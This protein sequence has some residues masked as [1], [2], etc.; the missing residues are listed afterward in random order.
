MTISTSAGDRVVLNAQYPFVLKNTITGVLFDR[1]LFLVL[2]Q[3]TDF[4]TSTEAASKEYDR[5][6]TASSTIPSVEVWPFYWL[7]L[8]GGF[9]YQRTNLMEQTNG[10]KGAIAG[11][12]LRF[13]T[14]DFDVNCTVMERVSRLVPKYETTDK[15]FLF[16]L[17][18]NATFCT[19][20]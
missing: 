16:Q 12:T 4:Y 14:W 7:S 3:I 18:K 9:I 2:K 11:I 15:R 13:G 6:G 17:S 5:L 10:G 8:R 1:R 19:S 20:R